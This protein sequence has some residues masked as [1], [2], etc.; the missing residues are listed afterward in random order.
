MKLLFPKSLKNKYCQE[1]PLWLSGL[2]TW[3]VSMRMQ[4]PSLASLSKLRIQC[5]HELQYKRQT[6]LG[7]GVAVAVAQAGSCSSDLIPSLG[8]S[9]CWGFSPKK[10]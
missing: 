7:S 6:L 8:T 9:L 1:F 2:Q 3:L 4:V 10:Q 5:C